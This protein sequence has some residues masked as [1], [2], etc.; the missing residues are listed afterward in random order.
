[1]ARDLPSDHPDVLAARR[2]RS[3]N[4]WPTGL[5]GFREAIVAYCATMEQLVRKLVRLYARA[6]RLPVKYFD[7]PFGEPQYKL[8]MT[9]YPYQTDLADDEF[10]IAPH[11]R[12]QFPHPCLP[13]M[14]SQVCRSARKA[15]NGS[16]HPP[17]LAPL[18]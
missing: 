8:R 9:H 12:Y 7:Q 18:S 17:F 3:A 16:M 2:F 5:P 15:A 10:G 1:V 14:T 6:L 11:H 4:R 13:P